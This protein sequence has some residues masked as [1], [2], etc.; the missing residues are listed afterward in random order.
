MENR[1]RE[2]LDNPEAL[3]KLYHE[4]KKVFRS[5]FLK[6]YPEISD[7]QLARFWEIGLKYD[8]SEAEI[9]LKFTKTDLLFLM[10]TCMISG[11]LIKLPSLFDL[12]LTDYFFYAKNGGLI[13]ILGL[14]IYAILTKESFK[15]GNL[16]ISAIVFLF[17]AIYI[18]L[19]PPDAKSNSINLAYIH[20]PLCRFW[21][22]TDLWTE[23]EE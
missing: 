22:S 3:E 20:L 17:S 13:V 15:R 5:G 7:S 1:I 6:L 19:L 8:A 16:I 18:N 21:I 9:R 11:F 2:F 23:I 14:S 4:D 10:I 12:G